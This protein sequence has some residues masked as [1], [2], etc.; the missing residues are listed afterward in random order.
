LDEPLLQTALLTKEFYRKRVI[1]RGRGKDTLGKAFSI[2]STKKRGFLQL[3]TTYAPKGGIPAK[4]KKKR[5][6]GEKKKKKK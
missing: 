4:K 3:F 5:K 6:K 2:P 1:K